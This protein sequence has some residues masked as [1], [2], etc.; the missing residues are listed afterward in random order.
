MALVV[1]AAV[2]VRTDQANGNKLWQDAVHLE[3][4]KVRVVFKILRNNEKPPPTFQEIHCHLVFDIKMEDFHRKA[5]FVAGGHITEA[6]KTLTYASVVS[7]ET[8]RI[9]LTLAALNDLE[10]K[11]GD[12]ENA[13]LPVPAMEKI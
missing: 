9:A 12:I 10:V 4:E 6:P 3:I 5:R 11:T 13:Y 8:V 7:R 1:A 2:R